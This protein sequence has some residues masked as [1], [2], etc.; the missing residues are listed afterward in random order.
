MQKENLFAMTASFCS[1][2]VSVY[3]QLQST[4]V[5]PLSTYTDNMVSKSEGESRF[6]PLL[7]DFVKGRA[8]LDMTRLV[9]GTEL[10][11]LPAQRQLQIGTSR[12]RSEE[13]GLK[14]QGKL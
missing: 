13:K 9:K 7:Y 10:L 12:V 2:P 11:T 14:T 4:R 1:L 5:L 8:D 6:E 3:R